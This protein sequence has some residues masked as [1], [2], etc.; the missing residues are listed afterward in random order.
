MKRE[1]YIFWEENEQDN[2]NNPINVTNQNSNIVS[3]NNT[4]INNAS[5]QAVMNSEYRI[6]SDISSIMINNPET[7]ASQVEN[8]SNIETNDTNNKD[9]SNNNRQ[10]GLLGLINRLFSWEAQLQTRFHPM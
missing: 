9:I 3:N 4:T 6:P 10:Y 2:Q 8:G 1:D 7:N 5:N